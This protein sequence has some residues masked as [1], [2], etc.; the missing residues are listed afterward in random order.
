MTKKTRSLPSVARG[1]CPECSTIST[2][3]LVRQ[4]GHLVW[5]L[6]ARA[7]MSGAQLECRASGV[8]LCQ[9]PARPITGVTTPTC[10]CEGRP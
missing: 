4:N 2:T 5:R 7:T 10:V 9:A 8:P 3:G 6:H 1:K